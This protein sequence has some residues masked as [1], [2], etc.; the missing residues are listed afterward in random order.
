MMLK[1]AKTLLCWLAVLLLLLAGGC[2][3][4]MEPEADPANQSAPGS[5]PATSVTDGVYVSADYATEELLS[6]PGTFDEY[7]ADDDSEYLVKLVFTAHTTVK[8]FR[9][10]A[11]QAE[12]A[13]EAAG[14]HLKVDSVLYSQD[15][16]SPDKPL[17]VGMV[18]VG[19]FPTRGISFVDEN[20]TTRYYAVNMSGKDGSI[21]L[22]GEEWKWIEAQSVERF[23]G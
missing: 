16:L 11:I 19:T 10:L 23:Y 6:R 20:G 8:D 7:V 14:F 2:V 22:Y 15:E 9:F 1:R 13:A 4:A 17:V 5:E 18:F 21:V 3:A 12:E